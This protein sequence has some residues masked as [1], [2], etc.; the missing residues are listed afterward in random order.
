MFK[1][2]SWVE[3]AP[4]IISL[5][6]DVAAEFGIADGD[7]ETALHVLACQGGM[8]AGAVRIIFS[9]VSLLDFEPILAVPVPHSLRPELV[10]LSRFV[11]TPKLAIFVPRI[12]KGLIREA[13]LHSWTRGY[14]AALISA[15]EALVPLYQRTVSSP[16]ISSLRRHPRT[17]RS[18]Q[19]M[20]HVPDPREGGV[21]DDIVAGIPGQQISAEFLAWLSRLESADAGRT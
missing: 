16:P 4:A 5:R 12:L 10:S 1:L 21:A 6:G 7:D 13:W 20:K 11:V 2:G 8:L 15:P 17:G 14:R 3:D 9:D 19:L 18:V